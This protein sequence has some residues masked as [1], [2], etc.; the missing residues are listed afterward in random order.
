MSI[1]F[2]TMDE[3]KTTYK[4][5]MTIYRMPYVYLAMTK[6]NIVDK[7]DVKKKFAN[8]C[9]NLCIRLCK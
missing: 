9:F 5:S 1:C 3:K 8:I 4:H 6:F 7:P 2:P